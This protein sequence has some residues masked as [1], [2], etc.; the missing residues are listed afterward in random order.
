MG[1]G[2]ESAIGVTKI[3]DFGIL[4]YFEPDEPDEAETVAATAARTP[5][6]HQ[7][8]ANGVD[9]TEILTKE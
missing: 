8:I 2:V 5:P 7:K 6:P 3:S 9:E 1:S 4:N